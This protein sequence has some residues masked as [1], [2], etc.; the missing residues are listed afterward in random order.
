MVVSKFIYSF[1]MFAAVPGFRVRGESEVASICGGM[2]S[3]ILLCFFVYVFVEDSVKIIN[4]Q[5]I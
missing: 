1:D 2:V 4:Y 3:I 5:K